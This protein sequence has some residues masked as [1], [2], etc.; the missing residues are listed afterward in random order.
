MAKAAVKVKNTDK[1]LGLYGWL[2][3]AGIFIIFFPVV[4]GIAGN[5]FPKEDVTDVRF[6]A[7]VSKSEIKQEIKQPINEYQVNETS[8]GLDGFSAAVNN[9]VTMMIWFIPINVFILVMMAV[10]KN[11]V[12]R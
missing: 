7:N 11:F 8:D 1:K 5:F 12:K 10:Y 4:V 2:T 3:I 9:T 6:S